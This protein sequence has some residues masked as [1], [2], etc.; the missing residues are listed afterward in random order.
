ME[1]SVARWYDR[2][3]RKD[4]PEFKS[5]AARIA[6]LVPAQGSVLEIAPGAGF[7]AIE[8]A[9]HELQV[10]GID[11][12]KTF[13]D[14]SRHNAVAAG[15]AVRFDLGNAAA[16]PVQDASQDFLVCRASL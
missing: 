12:S 7:L 1:G 2:T 6:R 13:V 8:L 16:L 5:M 3:T 9:R 15:V 4:M 11:I 10:R 14:I